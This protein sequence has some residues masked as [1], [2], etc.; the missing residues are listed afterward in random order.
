MAKI[1]HKKHCSCICTSYMFMYIRYSYMYVYINSRYL[2]ALPLLSRNTQTQRFALRSRTCRVGLCAHDGHDGAQGSGAGAGHSCQTWGCGDG[3]R[4]REFDSRQEEPWVQGHQPI[5]GREATT[6]CHLLQSHRL[7]LPQRFCF[8][9][10]QSGTRVKTI[11]PPPPLAPVFSFWGATHLNHLE[12][13]SGGFFLYLCR[14]LGFFFLHQ[15]RWRCTSA[16]Q[17]AEQLQFCILSL[18]RMYVPHNLLYL[19]PMGFC[20]CRGEDIGFEIASEH[21]RRI[22]IKV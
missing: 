1:R 4:C 14:V 6:I 19:S 8:R 5:A 17:R 18:T 16:W 12:W 20:C 22:A 15:C 2:L 9:W 13:V 3:A 11:P 21:L 10:L 7:P